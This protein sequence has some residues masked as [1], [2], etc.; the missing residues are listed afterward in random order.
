MNKLNEKT[1]YILRHGKAEDGNNHDDFRRALTD[2][3]A[4]DIQSTATALLHNP[5]TPERVISSAAVRALQTT[6]IIAA[7]LGV[8][9][10]QQKVHKALYEADKSLWLAQLQQ[11][12]ERVSCVMLVGHNP[13]LEV[14][15]RWLSGNVIDLPPGGLI[16]LRYTGKWKSIGDCRLTGAHYPG[17]YRKRLPPLRSKN[18]LRYDAVTLTPQNRELSLLSFHARVAQEAADTNNNPIERLTF[19][20]IVSSNLDEFYRVRM[21]SLAVALQSYKGKSP[22]RALSLAVQERVRGMQEEMTQL[23]KAIFRDLADKHDV[24]FVDEHS[25]N[26]A[27]RREAVQIFENE[28]RAG[29]SIVMQPDKKTLNSYMKTDTIYLAVRLLNK[30]GEKR[31]ALIEISTRRVSRFIPLPLTDSK[32]GAVRLRYL[33]LDDLLRLCLP[34]YLRPFGYEVE[35]AHCIKITRTAELEEN[36]SIDRRDDAE[37]FKILKTRAVGKIVRLMHDDEMPEDVLNYFQRR[38]DIAQGANIFPSGRYNNHRDL[39]GFRPPIRGTAPAKVKP[40]PVAAL[41]NGNH[42]LKTVTRQDV[43]LH[44]P[45]HSFRHIINMLREASLDP[46]VTHIDITLYRVAE[47]SEV[48]DALINAM[49]NGIEVRVMMEIKARFNE[50][51]NLRW[52]RLLQD[53]G[54]KVIDEIPDMKVHGKVCL[55]RRRNQPDVAIFSTGNYNEKTA[56][57]YC[58]T[59]LLT[60]NKKI[61]ADALDFFALLEQPRRRKIADKMTHL[62]T[63]PYTMR[64]QLVELIHREI[65]HAAAGRRA[66][67]YLKLNNLNDNGMTRLLEHA[68]RQGVTIKMIVRSTFSLNPELPEYKGRMQA[69]SIVDTLLEHA[70]VIVFA[71]NGNEQVYLSSADFLSRNLDRRFELA[72]PVLDK[73]L[74]KELISMLNLQLADT[75][76]A[77]LLNAE[78]DNTLQKIPATPRL[79]AQKA[80]LKLL[81]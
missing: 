79:R 11:L 25:I 81:Q 23:T 76:K 16:A 51:D 75:V 70:R 58:D 77:R 7:L 22:M 38:L 21:G 72:I 4:D 24:L 64:Q 67:I 40:Q 63:S 20:G 14:L 42:Y 10:K 50:E 73:A 5:I 15:L 30:D 34:D 57:L 27:Q 3:G 56:A 68:A 29:L 71:N 26:Q 47:S 19:A 80:L 6:R 55:I 78:Q 8:A 43:L 62:L 44:F 53:R 59:A 74:K 12:G 41:Q 54:I 39:I 36:N 46:Q 48:I 65:E 35:S 18:C 52:R 32:S 13:G 61:T 9:K 33:W 60:A 2:R 1:I 49:Y 37:I 66:C 28:V 31:Y 45:Y 69:V 17:R